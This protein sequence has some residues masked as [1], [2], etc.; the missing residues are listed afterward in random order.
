MKTMSKSGRSNSPKFT[1]KC[2]ITIASSVI[3][4]L[5]SLYI[6]LSLTRNILDASD[7]IVTQASLGVAIAVFIIAFLIL[8]FAFEWEKML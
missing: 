5:F 8:W 1:K 4:S 6:L 7:T 2:L 3:I